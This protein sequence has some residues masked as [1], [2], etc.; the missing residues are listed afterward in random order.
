MPE[1]ALQV[2]LLVTAQLEIMQREGGAKLKAF[3]GGHS[4]R[5]YRRLEAATRLVA[6][7]AGA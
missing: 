1:E 6:V 7:D 5:V 2:D 4:A 3:H